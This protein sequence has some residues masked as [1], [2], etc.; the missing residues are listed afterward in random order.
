VAVAVAVVMGL[1]LKVLV[2]FFLD[3]HPLVGVQA[4]LV[5]Y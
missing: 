2:A 4:R 5:V 1:E 3:F